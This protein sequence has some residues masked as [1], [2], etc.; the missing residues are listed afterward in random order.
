MKQ[1]GTSA[2]Q[3]KGLTGLG[4]GSLKFGLLGE[5]LS[6]SFSP[7][8][9]AELGNYEYCLYEKRHEELE[10]FLKSAD[11]DG[12]NVT[13]PYKKS[14]IPFCKNLSKT[15]RATGSV[16]TIT[17]LP[18]G[19]LYGDNTDCY[20]FTRLL[21]KTGINPGDGKILILGSGGS[22]LTVQTVL[23]DMNAKEIV[24]VSRNG[25]DNYSNIEEHSDAILLINTTPV[26]MYPNN[27]SSPLPDIGLFSQC[28]AVIDLIYNPARTELLLQAE[29]R[30]ILAVN[31][32]TMLA[33]Q[34]KKA[35][36]IFTGASIPDNI[37]ETITAKIEQLTLNITLIGM[38]GCGKTSM[39]AALAKMSG[40]L[41][42]DTDA[43]ITEAAGKP[44]PAIFAED[45]EEYF[46]RLE[47]D[48]LKELCKQSGLVIATGGGVVTQPCNRRIMRQNSIIVFLDRDISQL[49]VSG[50]PLSQRNGIAA[51][52]GER[53][54]LYSL[55]SEYTVKVCG[56]DET[57]SQIHEMLL[58]DKNLTNT[59]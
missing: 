39:G 37:I 8:I 49:P 21:H 25:K 32:L 57:V 13:I 47:T 33:A 54:P 45:G 16:N 14:V 4:A 51:L 52:A 12:L 55:W 48:T 28:R 24:I 59:L 15:A 34:A 18:D 29:E 30:G 11:F 1:M 5:Q 42:A 40:R 35:A 44:I 6:H 3:A 58:K 9:H 31:G 2:M 22:S 26:G 46:R 19:S 10:V 56:I 20:G 53:L 23:R 7:L 38:P 41:F 36:E 27:G 17:R 50:R 43:L